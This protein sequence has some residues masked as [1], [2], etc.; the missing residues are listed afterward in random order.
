MATPSKVELQ[1]IKAKDSDDRV[2]AEFAKYDY[3][4]TPN[5]RIYT[6]SDTDDRAVFV[7]IKSAAGRMKRKENTLKKLLDAKFAAGRAKAQK[8]ALATRA[9][10]KEK[11]EAQK[12]EMRDLKEENKQLKKDMRGFHKPGQSF[13]KESKSQVKGYY[14]VK[15]DIPPPFPT[16]KKKRKREE[17]TVVKRKKVGPPV[18]PRPTSVRMKKTPPKIGP[19]PYMEKGIIFM[20]DDP[21]SPIGKRKVREK[22]V[23]LSKL[24]MD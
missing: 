5:G 4:L 19:K 2:V 12:E 8:K 6:S 17:V 21:D 18:P 22:R 23:K 10:K 16:E 24:T 11:K 9:E 7:S 15:G 13:K 1:I 14:K 20:G 3:L